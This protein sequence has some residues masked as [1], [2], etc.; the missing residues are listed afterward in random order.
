M[1]MSLWVCVCK[2]S[3]SESHSKTVFLVDTIIELCAKRP[4]GSQ[5]ESVLEPFQIQRALYC[6]G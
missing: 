1:R 5:G 4:G 3:S 6:S 2:T